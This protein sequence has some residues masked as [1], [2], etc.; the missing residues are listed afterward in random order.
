MLNEAGIDRVYLA[1]GATDLRKSIDGLAVLVKE[2]FELD[3][4]SSCLFVFCNRKR[5]KL[6]ILHWEHNGFWL[7]YRRLEKGKFIWPQDTTSS[8]ITISRR[9]LR[10]LL[11]GLPL[12]QPKAHPEVKART[13][14]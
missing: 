2:G 13:I 4:F 11:D 12:K 1:C 14:L 3:P 9:E 10:W 6:K 5:D 8:T 7:Y